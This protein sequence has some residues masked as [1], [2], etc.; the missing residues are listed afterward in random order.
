[1]GS[2]SSPSPVDQSVVTRSVNP[3]VVSSNFSS[4]NI[5][6]DVSL[7]SDTRYSSS[8]CFH[9]KIVFVKKQQV[10]WKYCCREYWCEK[11]KKRMGMSTGNL[12]S[13]KIFLKTTLYPN[14][15]TRFV[16]QLYSVAC[17]SLTRHLFLN[18]H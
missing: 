16:Q 15:S 7:E 11:A 8:K 1:M 6:S 10:D 12:D 3:R 17:Y 14:L 5:F 13:T 9:G 2:F 18:E 4:A